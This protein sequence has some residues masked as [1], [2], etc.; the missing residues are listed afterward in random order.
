MSS[1]LALMLIAPELGFAQEAPTGSHYGGRASDTG[2]GGSLANVTGAYS[3][4]IPLA[5]PAER[6]GLPVPL[7]ISYGTRGVGAAGLGW[8]IPFSYI[9]RDRTFA[10]RRPAYFVSTDNCPPGDMRHNCAPPQPRERIFLSLLG[11]GGDLVRHGDTWVLRTGTLELAVR[12]SGG[13]FLAYD[14]AGR[15][16]S[17]CAVCQ[18]H[19]NSVQ[20]IP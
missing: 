5:L 20:P 2:F 13:E 15:T 9:R 14:G 6:A 7:Q 19:V 12:E 10:H 4:S 17:V 11:A 8:D 18:L 3:A 1:L 16:Y